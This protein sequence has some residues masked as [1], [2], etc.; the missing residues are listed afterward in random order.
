MIKHLDEPKDLAVWFIQGW[1]INMPALSFT[2]CRI[3][4]KNLLWVETNKAGS[5]Y[6]YI[7]QEVSMC[8]SGIVITYA[9]SLFTIIHVTIHQHVYTNGYNQYI[10]TQVEHWVKTSNALEICIRKV[11]F[12][13]GDFAIVILATELLKYCSAIMWIVDHCSFTNIILAVNNVHVPACTHKMWVP[14]L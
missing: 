12:S 6:D 8:H 13:N 2:T 9:M 10:K 4:S 14:L 11:L 3:N 7:W 1:E 5:S